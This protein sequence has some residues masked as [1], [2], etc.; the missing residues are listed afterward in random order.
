MHSAHRL[1]GD[2]GFSNAQRSFDG[3]D[4][5]YGNNTWDI[6]AMAG[7]ADQGVFNMN[8]NP[9][10]NVDIQYLG[11]TNSDCNQHV[12]WRIFALNYHDGRTGVTKTDNRDSVRLAADH[13]NIRI[14]TYD[15]DFLT[16]IP[17]GNG[18]FDFLFWGALQNGR[19][20]LLDHNANAVAFE[21]G[22]S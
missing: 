1:I 18:Q 21:V 6:S 17:V 22:I 2:S 10:L 9:E 15:G 13:Q 19:W 8:G 5:H 12:L 14:G 11:F 20:G 16:S 4:G 7:R 3:I